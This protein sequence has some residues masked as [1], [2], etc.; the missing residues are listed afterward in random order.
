M[1]YYCD[2]CSADL[3]TADAH[4]TCVLCLGLEHATQAVR[5]PHAWVYRASLGARLCE[6]CLAMMREACSKSRVP[7]NAHI[8]L[9]Q[10]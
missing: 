6:A 3:T 9:H 5:D 2:Q 4:S 1:L 10:G 7:P 8:F